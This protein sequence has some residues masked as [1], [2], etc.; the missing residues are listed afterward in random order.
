MRCRRGDEF[1]RGNYYEKALVAAA[2][3]CVVAYR[4]GL[5]QSRC[6]L[7]AGEFAMNGSIY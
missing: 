2:A 7:G 5:V 6:G 3:R 1:W 4:E